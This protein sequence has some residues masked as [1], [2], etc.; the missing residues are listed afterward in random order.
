MCFSG[1]KLN[2]LVFQDH[3]APPDNPGIKYHENEN[4]EIE[5]SDANSE[6]FNELGLN[7]DP[8]KVLSEIRRKNLNRPISGHIN[9]IFWGS[10]RF[11]FCRLAGRRTCGP[12]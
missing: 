11:C 10:R 6:I 4:S 9:I 5:H 8:N 12:R 2:D 3:A 1:D 7:E